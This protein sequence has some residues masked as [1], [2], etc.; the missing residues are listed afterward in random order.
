MGPQLR[1]QRSDDS[2]GQIADSTSWDACIEAI[3]LGGAIDYRSGGDY[4]ASSHVHAGY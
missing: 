4:A 3:D 1:E 2:G